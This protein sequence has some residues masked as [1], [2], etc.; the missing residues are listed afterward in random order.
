MSDAVTVN[1][2]K[3]IINLF[4]DL[5]A[6]NPQIVFEKDEKKENVIIRRTNASGSIAYFLLTPK[7]NFDF[8]G[9]ELAIYNYPEFYQM[10]S[11]LDKPVIKQTGNKILII[12]DSARLNYL[13]ANP[14]AVKK[15]KPKVVFND[16]DAKI[17]FSHDDIKEIQKMI[18]LVSAE[19]VEITTDGNKMNLRIFN[20]S[21]DNSFEKTYDMAEES[22][23]KLKIKISKEIFTI[24]PKENYSFEVKKEGIVKFSFDK[25]NV[26]LQIFTA[27]I[28]EE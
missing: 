20:T 27:E 11:C 22:K 24:L 3:E 14:E 23:A 13:I 25:E 10:F 9:D 7:D 18:G 28:E 17:I 16:A 21:H 6:I 4:N 19:Y 8:E 26:S 12:K 2:N 15:M 5:S 1:Y